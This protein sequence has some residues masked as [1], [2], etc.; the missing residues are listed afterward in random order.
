MTS[1]HL[2]RIKPVVL[3]AALCLCASASLASGEWTTLFNGQNLEGW[4]NPYDWG[5]AWVQDGQ[6][7]LPR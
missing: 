7:V 5:K 1:L 4:S 2:H 6:I 3:L